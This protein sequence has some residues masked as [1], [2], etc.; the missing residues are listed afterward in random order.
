VPV[1]RAAAPGAVPPGGALPPRITRASGG[2]NRVMGSTELGYASIARTVMFVNLRS[3]PHEGR[4]AL[5]AARRLGFEV[6][7]LADRV[8]AFADG[9]LAGL[10]IVD[11]YNLEQAVAAAGRPADRFSPEGLVTWGD[12]DVELLALQA[13]ATG[14]R[15][16]RAFV[17]ETFLDGPQF[18]VEGWV[19]DGRVLVAG[20]TD[21]WTTE[22]FHL[23]YQHIH[24]SELPPAKVAEIVRNSELVVRTL[25]L[26]HCAFHLECKLG[27]E[28]FRV[29]EVAARAGGDYITSHLIPLSTGIDFYGDTIRVATGDEPCSEPGESL[30]AGVRFPLARSEG[31]LVGSRDLDAV[32]RPPEVEHVILEQA[33]G[34]TIVLPPLE[35]SRQR[36]AAVIT[37]HPDYVRVL[38]ALGRAG[39]HHPPAGRFTER[40]VSLRSLPRPAR[41]SAVGWDEAPRHDF[42][43][44]GAGPSNLSL[45]A[46]AQPASAWMGGS[47]RPRRSSA[48][49]PPGAPGR[50]A[51]GLVPEGPRHPRRSHE[52]PLVPVVPARDRPAAPVHRRRRAR[53]SPVRSSRSTTPGW[54]I[55]SARCDLAGRWTPSTTMGGRS[56]SAAGAGCCAPGTSCSAR[57]RSHGCR[58]SPSRSPAS[59][60]STPTTS[61]TS[62][63][64][65]SVSAS[66][67]SVAARAR[68]RSSC[69]S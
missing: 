39:C 57:A 28:G 55:A 62:R 45:A 46:L 20:I 64:P 21:K 16:G 41:G 18:S 66:S 42:V 67:W 60:C 38:H 44:V 51:A 9:Q 32:L 34:E 26:D 40:S 48:G 10:E 15:A 14:G 61:W 31:Q 47:S 52:P 50:E 25:G 43:G 17:L 30:H 4:R 29:V 1:A 22:P 35:F 13:I 56:S 23:E 24:P 54:P 6:V 11:T 37:R 65:W 19:Y 63:L 69:T 53:R 59:G 3:T 12:R 68:P 49:I 7:L 58:R 5:F 2:L 8:P 36:V 27:A 33:P